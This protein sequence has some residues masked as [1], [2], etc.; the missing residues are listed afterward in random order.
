VYYSGRGSKKKGRSSKGGSMGGSDKP[1]KI[2]VVKK[3]PPNPDDSDGEL[4]ALSFFLLFGCLSVCL[5]L[6]LSLFATASNLTNNSRLHLY[7]CITT[8]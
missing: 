1:R 2:P 7:F 3:P 6:F 8:Y 4:L 5:R